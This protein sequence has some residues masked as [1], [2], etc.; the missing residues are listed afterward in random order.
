MNK[1]VKILMVRDEI[2]RETAEDMVR[3]CRD[4]IN[5][6]EDPCEVDDIISDLL[7]LEPDYLFDILDFK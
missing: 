7:E 5:E 3:E 2:D 1:V 4:M 6:A